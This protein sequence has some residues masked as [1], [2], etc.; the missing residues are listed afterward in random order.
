[1]QPG[2]IVRCE[3]IFCKIVRF[4]FA[5]PFFNQRKR[6]RDAQ[7]VVLGGIF[8]KVRPG[9]LEQR[10][11]RTE[12]VLLQMNKRTGQ[13]NEALVKGMIRA[14]PVRQP[15]RFENIMR[16]V[17]EA[18]IEALEITKIMRVQI[19]PAAVFDESRDFCAF[20]AHSIRVI[21][22]AKLS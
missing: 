18:L 14:V 13:L 16:L 4:Q 8:L 3:R 15:E 10:R 2:R 5:Q 19:L 21:I 17:K 12:P 9:Q 22:F 6:P 11:G 20:F 7:S 1:M